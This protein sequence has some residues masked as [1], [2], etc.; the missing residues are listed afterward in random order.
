[1]SSEIYEVLSLA[2]RYWFTFLGVLIVWRAFRWLRKD[3]R[4]KH[5][6]LK[7]LPDAGM[8][9]ELVVLSGGGELADGCA[10][11]LPREGVLGSLRTCDVTLPAPGVA[12]RHLDFVF[13]DGLGLMIL[14]R[15]HCETLV[16]GTP[17]DSHS[18]PKDAPMHH[19][20][21]LQVGDAVL[22]LRLFVGL[23][24]GN[25]PRPM[26]LNAEDTAAPLPDTPPA[27]WQ[28]TPYIYH[29]IPAEWADQTGQYAPPVYLDPESG[30][31]MGAPP[32]YLD[33]ESGLPVGAPPVYLDPESGLPVGAPTV[34]LDP[35]SGLPPPVYLDP[36]SGL[37]MGAPPVYLDPES[38][39]PVGA[40]PVYLDPESGLPV[41]APTVYLDPESGLPMSS[42]L[43]PLPVQEPMPPHDDFPPAAARDRT[44]LHPRRRNH[45]KN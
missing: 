42:G 2:A 35:E 37:P 19:G 18:R 8:V 45:G 10:L 11:P 40:P 9:G 27:D 44:R 1:M 28:S 7:Q 26:T 20:S 31:P 25:A 5:R 17:L 21:R 14:P 36:E 23:E 33:P 39:L 4:A 38:G 15:F 6:R 43:P 32:V 30:L 29:Q 3:R 34:Y 41:G 16:D 12:P 24:T 13:E 22:R